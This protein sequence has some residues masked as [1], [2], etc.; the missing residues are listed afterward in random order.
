MSIWVMNDDGI[1]NRS[2]R[3]YDLMPE[4]RYH[5]GVFKMHPQPHGPEWRKLVIPLCTVYLLRAM[6]PLISY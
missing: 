5:G 1:M 3:Y 4:I 2:S 6:P